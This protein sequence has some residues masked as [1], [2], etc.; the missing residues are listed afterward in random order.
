MLWT[1]LGVSGGAD[2]AA[3]TM[4]LSCELWASRDLA[5]QTHLLS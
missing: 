4:L 5:W 2:A 3:M 1:C